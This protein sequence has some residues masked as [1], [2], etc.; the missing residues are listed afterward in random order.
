[1]YAEGLAV[2]IQVKNH[3]GNNKFSCRD[4]NLFKKIN[5]SNNSNMINLVD[6]FGI[7]VTIIV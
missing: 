1:M 7:C 4:H 6:V 3:S 5:N 2:L